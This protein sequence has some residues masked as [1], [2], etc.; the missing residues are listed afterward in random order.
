[1]P[2]LTKAQTDN[3]NGSTIEDLLSVEFLSGAETEP[4]IAYRF[5]GVDSQPRV[6]SITDNM[7]AYLQITDN[8][9]LPLQNQ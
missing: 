6:I 3:Q 2:A 1:M 4:G 7:E 8:Q 5:Y 9:S